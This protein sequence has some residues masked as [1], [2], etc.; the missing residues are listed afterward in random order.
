MGRGAITLF[1]LT[2]IA[3][4]AGGLV[5]HAWAASAFSASASADGLRAGLTVKGLPVTESVAD[6]GV[7]TAQAAVDSLGNSSGYA[8]MPYPG[9]T[10]ITAGSLV[11]VASSGQVVPPPYP[12]YATTKFPTAPD[13]T[14]S[15]G[16]LTLK[17]HSDAQHTSSSASSG[18]SSGGAAVG[19]VEATADAARADDGTVKSKGAATVESFMAGPLAIG[20]MKSTADVTRPPGGDPVR[21]SSFRASGVTVT[22]QAV[23]LTDKGLT[24]GGT[25][26]PLPDSSSLRAALASAG[27]DVQPLPLIND[28]DGIVSAGVLVSWTRDIPNVGK[29][30]VTYLLGRTAAHAQ[31]AALDVAPAAVPDNV[32]APLAASAGIPA[33]SGSSGT[34][35]A[36]LDALATPATGQTP[37]VRTPRTATRAA[38]SLQPAARSI[39]LQRADWARGFYAVMA[40]AGIVMVVGSQ[41]IRLL[42]VRLGWTSS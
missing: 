19:F 31:A 26:T 14:V 24:V 28:P 8:S 30:T 21:S 41:V 36:G 42:G 6:V 27:L 4:G 3:G 29:G 35:A 1:G 37:S 32:L 10:V 18:A 17:S 12:L 33:V 9:D 16:P 5:G 7:P 2:F 38:G 15:Q 23:G 20:E 25:D 34:S 40:A 11:A 39:P 22:G 13:A